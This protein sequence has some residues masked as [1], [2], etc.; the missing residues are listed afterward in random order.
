[1]FPNLYGVVRRISFSLVLCRMF[2]ALKHV[3]TAYIVSPRHWNT[4]ISQVNITVMIIQF[5]VM[6]VKI[7]MLN[8]TVKK[9]LSNVIKMKMKRKSEMITKKNNNPK[10]R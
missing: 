4:V 7:L 8:N 6:I 2:T 5:T 1:M 10:I 3:N 9:G